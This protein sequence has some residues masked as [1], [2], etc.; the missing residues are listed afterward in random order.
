ME[1][2]SVDVRNQQT[3]WMPCMRIDWRL[4]GDPSTSAQLVC[5]GGRQENPQLALLVVETQVVQANAGEIYGS[6]T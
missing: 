3:N 6:P 2:V 4:N 5:L 1:L